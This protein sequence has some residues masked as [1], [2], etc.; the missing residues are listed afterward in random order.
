MWFNLEKE[1]FDLISELLVKNNLHGLN[2]LLIQNLAE[3][4]PYNS[5]YNK[6]AAIRAAQIYFATNDVQI[7]EDYVKWDED[8][9]WVLTWQKVPLNFI[10]EE[11]CGCS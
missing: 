1:E 6:K 7:D 2:H 4:S 9:A 11:D 3:L 10:T 8:C 5:K